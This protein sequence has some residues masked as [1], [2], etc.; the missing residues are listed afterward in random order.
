M[1]Y[2]VEYSDTA[3]STA[4]EKE[5]PDI[6]IIA[7]TFN[8]PDIF[9]DHFYFAHYVP[10]TKYVVR[11]G[12]QTFDKFIMWSITGELTKDELNDLKTN[13]PYYIR[14]FHDGNP[15]NLTTIWFEIPDGLEE[16]IKIYTEN[17]KV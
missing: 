17:E 10:W 15:V 5:D 2:P 14:Y 13:N 8:L 11:R 1:S 6:K 16:K 4:Y 12:N 9:I 7:E 3:V